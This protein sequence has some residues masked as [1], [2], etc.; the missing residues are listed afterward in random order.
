MEKQ[1]RKNDDLLNEVEK[2]LPFLEYAA[3]LLLC[4]AVVVIVLAMLGPTVGNVFSNT[5]VGL[6][7]G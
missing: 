4:V 3:I 5:L 7:Y 2:P 1:K 6:S